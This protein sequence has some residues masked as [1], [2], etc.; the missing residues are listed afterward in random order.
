[1]ARDTQS[2]GTS[3]PLTAQPNGGTP[4][5]LTYRPPNGA[6]GV[7]LGTGADWFGPLNPMWP[8]APQEVKGRILDFPS[9]YN[10]QIQPRSYEPITFQML[11]NFA[12]GYDLLRI[13]IETRKDQMANLTWNI[14]PRNKGMRKRGSVVPTEMQGRIEAIEE[15]FIR[16]D[17]ENFWDDWLRMLLEDLLVID[18]PTIYRR[19]T[20]GGRLFAL[21]PIDGGTVKRV[22]DDW[23]NTPAPPSPAYQQVLK[24]YPA[25]DYTADEL[26]YRPRNKRTHKVYGYSPVEQI[27]MT[28][29]I[30]IRRETWQLQSFS[31]GNIPEALIGT[32][33]TWTPDQVA[34]FQTWFDSLLI[35]NTGERRRARFVPGAV[36]KGYVPTKPAELFGD[37]EEWLIRVMCY[38]FGVSPQ[39]FVK[40]MNRATAETAQETASSEGLAPLQ[41]W[42]KGLMNTIL[43]DDFD[44]ADLEFVWEDEQ[45]LDPNVK[46][47]IIDREQKAGRLTYNEARREMG[48]DPVSEPNA[49]RP[50]VFIPT[51]GWSPIFPTPEEQKIKDALQQQMLDKQ[52]GAPG[53]DE[54]GGDPSDDAGGTDDGSDPSDTPPDDKEVAKKSDAPFLRTDVVEKAG[55]A[56]GSKPLY[57]DPLRPSVAKQEK[58]LATS[59]KAVLYKLGAGVAEQ[60]VAALRRLGKA[61]EPG[62][63]KKPISEEAAGAYEVKVDIDEILRQLD[64]EALQLAEDDLESA[65]LAV[66]LDASNVVLGSMDLAA[67]TQIVDRVN[68]RAVA[69]ARE[70]AAELVSFEGEEPLLA[71]T[72]RDMLR[73]TIAAGLEE[74]IGM[75]AIAEEIANSYAF[76]EDRAEVIAATEV[77]SANSMG[78]LASFKEAE[79]V[80]VNVKKSWLV[81]EDGCPICQAN[82]DDGPI[83]LDEPFSSGDMAPGAHPHCRCTLVPEVSDDAEKAD[84]PR[85]TRGRFSSDPGETFMTGMVEGIPGIKA[86]KDHKLIELV[87]EQDDTELSKLD[88]QND[89]SQ[90]FEV[91]TDGRGPVWAMGGNTPEATAEREA[92]L[93]QFVPFNECIATQDYCDHDKVKLY[94]E[95]PT[96]KGFSPMA[97]YDGLNY[98]IQDGHHRAVASKMSGNAGMSMHVRTIE[99]PPSSDV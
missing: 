93:L 41:K 7:T 81:L 23:G 6:G 15:F 37:A 48:D 8:I 55:K 78:A 85:N 59:L 84:Q 36:A 61:D 46:S 90:F 51:Q 20:Y 76:S 88:N 11:R 2:M 54:K 68:E 40:M 71:E 28:I 92:S 73:E 96:A 24:G 62:D 45:E 3:I 43:I 95:D 58:A 9:G 63:A 99:L 17:R 75:P 32:P 25:V 52:P 21:Q 83:D 27:V 87:Q 30:G 65:L 50:M 33:D 79:A 22:I 19:R 64:L 69:Y 70:R 80:G 74:N 29:N 4:Y 12:D 14:V 97:Y 86:K 57:T 47:Q 34:Q 26:I 35:N 60:I 82:A 5:Q 66:E 16:P 44:S 10:L 18:A 89:M 91:D 49:D 42:V 31:E 38:A 77:T 1:M 39:P 13:L 72:T 98:Y 94:I 67:N 56:T 53:A